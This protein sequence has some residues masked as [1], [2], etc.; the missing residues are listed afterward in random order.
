MRVAK[1]QQKYMALAETTW[2]EDWPELCVVAATGPSLTPEV[3]ARCAGSSVIAVND[4]YRLFPSSVLYACDARWWRHYNGVP[5]FRGEKWSSHGDRMHNNK[6]D[7]ARQ[8]GLNLVQGQNGEG[9][10][11][12]RS[13][14]NYGHNS[15]FQAINLGILFGSTRIL[16]VG[17]DM[18]VVDGK[19][20]FFGEHP[21]PMA[22]N[23]NYANWFGAFN[24][25]AQLLPGF[26]KVL[27]CTPD[28]ALTCFP[29][30]S[31][32]EA[33]NGS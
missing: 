11:L 33:L 27:N 29:T 14:I 13:H 18:R 30:M 23:T 2:P 8:Y 1:P 17:F 3:A 12:D 16:L 19:R 6:L 22:R 21:P 31:L 9:F 10:S 32:D 26:I 7:V 24:K 15:G 5:E 4:A 25:A 20:H 28:S